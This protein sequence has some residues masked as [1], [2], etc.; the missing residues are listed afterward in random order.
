MR[1]REVDGEPRVYSYSRTLD[2]DALQRCF[3]EAKALARGDAA[4]LRRIELFEI[5]LVPA[6][7]EKE[8]VEAYDRGDS[9]VGK[10]AQAK[11]VEW[12]K[13]EAPKHMSSVNPLRYWSTYSTPCRTVRW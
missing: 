4:V 10:A 12:S 5:G 8:I 2:I 1:R 7:F 11:F 13:T 9:A 3:N 6:R